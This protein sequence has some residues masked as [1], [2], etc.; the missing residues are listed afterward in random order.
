MKY[1]SLS[2]YSLSNSAVASVAERMINA[3]LLEFMLNTASS[4]H[5][6]GRNEVIPW[7][8]GA[9]F[10]TGLAK[11]SISALWRQ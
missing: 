9:A 3:G 11:A 1:L 10:T 7:Y 8:V 5:G 6:A 4:S 2:L